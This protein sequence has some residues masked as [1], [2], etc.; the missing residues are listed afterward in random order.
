MI[1]FT[2]PGKPKGKGRPRFTGK[3]TYTPKATAD[4]EKMIR[5]EYIR[6]VGR[7]DPIEGPVIA[8][9]SCYYQIPKGDSKAKRKAKVAGEIPAT[10]KPDLDNVAKAVLDSL[11]GLAFEDD[12]QVISLLVTKRYA[13]VGRIDV[14]IKEG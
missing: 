5:C 12:A 14:T 7:R 3:R 11:N 10:G 1:K 2:I 4:Y 9:I 6:Q 8:E 13:E